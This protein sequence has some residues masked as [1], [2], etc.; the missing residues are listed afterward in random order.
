MVFLPKR[1]I[2]SGGG[3]R[4]LIFLPALKRLEL[5]GRLH[6]VTEWWGTSAGSL[7]AALMGITKSANRVYDIMWQTSYEKFRDISLLNMVNFTSVWGL[8]D[9]HSMVGEIERILELA[10]KG[11]SQWTLADVSGLHI[12]V[13]D[14]NLY[15]TVVCS[16]ATFP[17]LRLVDAIRASMSLPVMYRPF[18]CPVNGHIWVDGGLRAAF[19]WECLPTKEARHESLGFSFEKSWHLGPT[20]FTEY[21]FSMLHFE[22]PKQ[23]ARWKKE[24]QNIIWFPSPPFPAWYVRLQE[25]DRGLLETMANEA[26]DRWLQSESATESTSLQNLS[27]IPQ[28]LQL[29]APPCTPVQTDPGHHINGR[30]DIH[31]PFYGPSRALSRDSQSHIQPFY[32]RWSL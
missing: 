13:A 11:A 26:T 14:L 25:D 22:D 15:E 32:R 7:L 5:Q 3:T 1:L 12:V 21:M 24:W 9:G 10:K 19:P 27:R 30:S 29:S 16:Q 20:T 23:I 2:F 31:P 6:G 17:T 28:T 18:R 4:C 8:D